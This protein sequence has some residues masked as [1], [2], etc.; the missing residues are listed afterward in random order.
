MFIPIGIFDHH[1]NIRV[2]GF[3]RVQDQF[4]CCILHQFQA[5]FCPAFFFFCRDTQVAFTIGEEEIIQD[6]FIKK[7]GCVGG[8][9]LY[10][11]TV[12]GIGITE[13]FKI[14]AFV[15]GIGDATRHF[16][17]PVPEKVNRCFQCFFINHQQIPVG[18]QV[19]L[20]H[21]NLF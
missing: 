10:F 4:N 16:N 15:D 21:M 6:D 3:C 13:R 9:L 20:I 18:F 11:C 7:T 17:A 14:V 12:V 2:H 1:L 8:Y 5:V 19:N